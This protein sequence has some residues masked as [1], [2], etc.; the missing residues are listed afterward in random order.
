MITLPSVEHDATY[1]PEWSLGKKTKKVEKANL[2]F[3]L[4]VKILISLFNSV[5]ANPSKF[6]HK[7]GTSGSFFNNTA[8]IL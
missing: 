8:I 6:C 3:Y 1:S 5:I 2:N 4:T 7:N